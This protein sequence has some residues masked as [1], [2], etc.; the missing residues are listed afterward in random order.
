MAIPAFAQSIRE[1]SAT[2]NEFGVDVFKLLQSSDAKQYENT[3][4]CMLAITAIQVNNR[5]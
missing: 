5:F 3:L 1:C 4:N 2:L